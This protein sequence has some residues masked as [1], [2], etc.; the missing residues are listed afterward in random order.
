MHPRAAASQN[1]EGNDEGGDFPRSRVLDVK[2]GFD[3]ETSA[4]QKCND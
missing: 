4:I 3:C 1:L 2:I